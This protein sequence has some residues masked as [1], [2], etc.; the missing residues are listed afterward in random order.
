VGRFISARLSETVHVTDFMT[1]AQIADAQSATPVLDCY[2]AVTA[3]IAA[4]STSGGSVYIPYGI[5]ARVNSTVLVPANV[6]LV[7]A[8][9]HSCGLVVGADVTAV[10][11]TGNFAKAKSFG[12]KKAS[13]FTH[14]KTGLDVGDASNDAGRSIVDDVYVTG[15]GSDGIQ[16]RNGNLGTLRDI[17]S[18]INGR[19][20]INFTTETPDNNAWKLEGFLDLRGNV[21]DGLNFAQGSSASDPYAPKS[22]QGGLI[23]AQSNG[24]YGLYCGT[25]SNEFTV[26]AESNGTDIYIDTYAYGNEITVVQALAITDNGT[27]NIITTHSMNADYIRGFISQVI[28]SGKASKGL[29]ISNDDGTVGTVS[30]QKTGAN[31]YKLATNSSGGTHVFS[32]KNDDGPTYWRFYGPQLIDT[33]PAVASNAPT[34]ASA[35]TIAPTTPIAFVSG[36]TTINTITAPTPFANGGGQITL[37]PT[38]LWATSNAGNIAIASTAVVSKA[39]ILT[40]DVTTGK[41]YPS[42]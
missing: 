42:Y 24:R 29:K 17:T 13:G 12:I 40:Y 3:A 1:L 18:I 19:D 41:W 34:L 37:I 36:T 21:R 22:N 7:G 30:L 26:Y 23:V 35:G 31:A 5:W 8:G 6:E 32:F 16:V 28:F 11:L 38:G 4:V 14:T 20:G 2:S 39:L 9:S 15:M 33:A 27:G 10:R 25:R